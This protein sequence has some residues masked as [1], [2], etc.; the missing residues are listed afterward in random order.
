MKNLKTEAP[1]GASDHAIVTGDFVTEWKS[2]AAQKPR[3]MYHKG[4]YN[5]IMEKPN[6]VNWDMVFENKTVQECWDIFKLEL[7]RLVKEYVP[8]STPKDY[9]EPWMNKG[10][11][12]IWKKKYHLW[13]R[14][15]ESKSYYRHQ[16]YKKEKQIY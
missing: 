16:M 7:I 9:N 5:K 8:E 3:K 4:N 13:K 2:K 15:T 11:M 6:L 1:L 14:Y 10:L 12:K